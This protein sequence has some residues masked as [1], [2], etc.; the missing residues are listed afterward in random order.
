MTKYSLAGF[1][2][3]LPD[4]S[5]AKGIRK[6]DPPRASEASVARLQSRESSRNEIASALER[7]AARMRAEPTPARCKSRPRSICRGLHPLGS[8]N[9]SSAP[10]RGNGK[11][12]AV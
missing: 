6:P 10:G 12:R 1:A 2:E 3:M 5:A 7:L 4:E 11:F 9:C 8:A